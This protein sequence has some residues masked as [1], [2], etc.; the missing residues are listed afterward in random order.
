MITFLNLE[1]FF[2]MKLRTLK[3]ISNLPN[4]SKK[5]RKKKKK[6]KRKEKKKDSR[7]KDAFAFRVY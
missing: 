6:K 5:E 4:P 3:K 1:N 7:I 2:F